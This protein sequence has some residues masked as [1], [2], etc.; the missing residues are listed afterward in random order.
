VLQ[1]QSCL[2]VFQ[3]T[4]GRFDFDTVYAEAEAELA[5]RC[6]AA[7]CSAAPPID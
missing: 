1:T 6:F 7:H 3:F 4:V 5:I 2:A